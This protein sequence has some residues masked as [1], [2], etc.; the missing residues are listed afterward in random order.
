MAHFQ[1]LTEPVI[2]QLSAK[3]DKICTEAKEDAFCKID[4]LETEL[5]KQ[6]KDSNEQNDNAREQL[7]IA[8]S[9]FEEF[10]KF[11]KDWD[12]NTFVPEVHKDRLL[13][14]IKNALKQK[15]KLFLK[16]TN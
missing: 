4:I 12:L 5:E 3:C 14:K 9:G 6:M 7:R 15:K 1:V 16:L 2:K 13:E 10:A 8:S 11:A